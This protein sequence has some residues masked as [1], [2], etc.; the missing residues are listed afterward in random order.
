[1]NEPKKPRL[2]AQSTEQARRDLRKGEVG[3]IAGVERLRQAE[4]P[5]PTKAA[6]QIVS[7]GPG[8]RGVSR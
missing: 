3:D 7:D 6:E 5:V 1:M 8:E 2:D 4:H